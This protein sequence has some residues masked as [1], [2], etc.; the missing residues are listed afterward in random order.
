MGEGPF[1]REFECDPSAPT[2]YSVIGDLIT[3]ANTD[4]RITDLPHQPTADVCV[5]WDLGIR[6]STAL[7]LFQLVGRCVHIIGYREFSGLG[8]IDIIHRLRKEHPAYAWGEQVLPH[9]I[10]A[11]EFSSGSSRLA[12]F[13]EMSFGK[14]RPL[15]RMPVAESIHMARLN[16]SRC[17][18]DAKR[19]EKGLSHLKSARYEVDRIVHNDASHGLD[20]FKYL[21]C[22]V[23]AR[24]P[25][26]RAKSFGKS[27][28][29]Q[30]VVINKYNPMSSRR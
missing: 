23:E 29:A 17:V 9:D 3:Q 13:R 2:Q 11:R 14:P 1:L 15:K 16:M 8:L 12:T 20:S 28:F 4:G 7:W 5:S 19:C 22:W 21:S 18:F 26:G 10:S 24:N 25:T 27:T 30:P 6:D